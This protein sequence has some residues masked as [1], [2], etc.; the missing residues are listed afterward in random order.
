MDVDILWYSIFQWKNENLL[1][2][3]T[4]IFLN[5]AQNDCFNTEALVVMRAE[6]F[7]SSHMMDVHQTVLEVKM[8]S[9]S[10]ISI[11][12]MSMKVTTDCTILLGNQRVV[13]KGNFM[14][15]QRS[16]EDVRFAWI[17]KEY[18]WSLLFN[19]DKY[20]LFQ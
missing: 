1:N 18:V 9:A 14:D 6:A 4:D 15:L 2:S 12:M 7:T 13:Q 16:I 8:Y 17:V 11:D 3:Q 5:V 19:L 10:N 20:S